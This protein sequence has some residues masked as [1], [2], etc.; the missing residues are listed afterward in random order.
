MTGGGRA[1][2]GFAIAV[3]LFAA[4]VP[5]FYR[6]EVLA[7]PL[8]PLVLLTAEGTHWLLQSIGIAATREGAILSAPGGFAYEVYYRC[9]GFLP[10]LCLLVCV[11]AYPAALRR[12]LA[13][14]VVGVPLLLAFNLIRLVHLFHIG[15]THPDLFGLSHEVLWEVA[16]VLAVALVWL[17]YMIWC[18][19]I[20]PD[21]ISP[22]GAARPRLPAGSRLA[23]RPTVATGSSV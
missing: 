16:T 12:K 8:A 2:Y 22:H 6:Q 3:A 18:H 7:E 23:P 13:G 9:T 4:A 5:S 15:V 20:S 21:R 11:L 17:G 1:L 10:V 14:L 19:G